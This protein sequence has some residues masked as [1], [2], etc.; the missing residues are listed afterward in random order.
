[1]VRVLTFFFWV[2]VAASALTIL[3]AA[4][5]VSSIEAFGWRFEI[6]T[7][8]GV[9]L[10]AAFTTLVTLF[11]SFI[12]D[13]AN[14]P[15][16]ARARA[17][18]K[19]R[20]RG[21]AALTG[22]FNAIAAGDVVRAR[23]YAATAL[24]ALGDA[25]A[26]KL[27]S[28]RSALL[29][30]DDAA[31]EAALSA[32]VDAPETEFLALQGLCLTAKA[33]GDLEAA[34]RHAERVFSAHP[35]ARWAFDAVFSLALDRRDFAGARD[36]V[37]AA[38]KAKTIE[39]DAAARGAAA[40]MTALAFKAH[41]AGADTAAVESADAALKLSPALAPAAIL[42]ARLHA[43]SGDRKK[44]AKVLQYAF[45]AAGGAAL[46]DAYE[47]FVG[48]EPTTARAD[49]LDRFADLHPAARSAALLRARAALLRGETATATSLLEDALKSSA[50]AGALKLMAEVEAA[51]HGEAAAHQWLVRAASAPRDDDLRAGDYFRLDDSAWALLVRDY[52]DQARLPPVAAPPPGLA[53]DDLL[54][55]APPPLMIEAPPPPPV[56]SDNLSTDEILDRDV[57]AARSAN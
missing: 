47:A 31:A 19:R 14:A 8:V 48:D 51:R 2:I 10:I 49:S 33:T 54:R 13:L 24:K 29:S 35:A 28:A 37:L 3:L 57:A 17:E 16:R 12:K 56:A 6:A 11:A 27:L 21:L 18:V 46:A 7:G 15:K 52:M 43:A 34:R 30:G 32:L 50:S 20:E 38:A 23:K 44:A 26:A 36:A 9:F 1:M 41:G 22:G 39:E 5:S 53:A 45:S 42:S 25:P 40:A 55:L 4:D